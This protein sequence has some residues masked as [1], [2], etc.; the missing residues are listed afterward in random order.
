M[1][2]WVVEQVLMVWRIF[3]LQWINNRNSSIIFNL[4]QIVLHGWTERSG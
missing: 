4:E 2:T 1:S 3:G